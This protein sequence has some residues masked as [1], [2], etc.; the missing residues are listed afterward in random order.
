MLAISAGLVAALWAVKYLPT[1]DGPEHVL[2]GYIE[3][4][5]EDAGS[6]YRGAL[7]LLPGFASR[8][9]ALLFLPFE[10][11]FGWAT[12]LKLSQSVMAL[13]ML[14]GFTALVLALERT[15]LGDASPGL[16][17]FA[18]PLGVVV[19]LPW[20]FYMGFFPNTVAT[21]RHPRVA[22][23]LTAVRRDRGPARARPGEPRGP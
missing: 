15:R 10:A 16:R 5:Y 2:S 14:W 13:A 3:N 17:R 19:A 18:A 22:E 4:H 12:A 20:V 8:G 11:F 7:T 9:F 1:N 21:A 6:P 23:L